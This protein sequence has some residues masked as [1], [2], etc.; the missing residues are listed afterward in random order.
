MINQ[1]H[2]AAGESVIIYEGPSRSYPLILEPRG[3]LQN[4]FGHFPHETIRKRALGARVRSRARPGGFVRA[5]R[6]TPEL[7]TAALPHRT[8]VLYAADTALVCLRLGLRPG[9]LVVES[10]T[11]S[12]SLTHALARAVGPS[13]HVATFEFSA[14]R[15]ARA[16]EDFAAHGLSNVRCVHRDAT[17]PGGAAFQPEVERGAADAVFLD[18]PQ[19]WDALASARACL[20]ACGVLCSFS[21]C[22]EQVMRVCALLTELGFEDVRTFETLARQYDVGDGDGLAVAPI[23]LGEA[24][25][26]VTSEGAGFGDGMTS[27]MRGRG[28]GDVIADEVFAC[29]LTSAFVAPSGRNGLVPRAWPSATVAPPPISVRVQPAATGRGHTGYLTFAILF[30]P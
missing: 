9:A 23:E 21:P 12:G 15:A 25:L 4:R 2:A 30:R 22:V 11:G 13:G 7:W 27:Q 6:V 26:Q 16:R 28:E 24:I 14:E 8:Q 1:S 17:R 20:R 29:S 3:Q 19:P 18:L 5:L 10:G